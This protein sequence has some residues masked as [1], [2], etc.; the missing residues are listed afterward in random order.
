MLSALCYCKEENFIN[1]GEKNG[2]LLHFCNSIRSFAF[3]NDLDHFVL[4]IFFLHSI[5][6][7]P[8]WFS[9]NSCG[10]CD[11]IH[12]CFCLCL[13]RPHRHTFRISRAKR[14]FFFFFPSFNFLLPK[15]KIFISF[16]KIRRVRRSG[17]YNNIMVVEYNRR[18]NVFAVWPFD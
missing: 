13:S 11:G 17:K 8:S 6:H 2:K 9:L 10:C 14:I 12:P 1:R 15:N 3:V 5:S 7:F 16:L 18:M 4:A